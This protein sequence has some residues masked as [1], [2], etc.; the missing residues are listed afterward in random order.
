MHDEQERGTWS[1]SEAER[2]L[3]AVLKYS[4]QYIYDKGKWLLNQIYFSFIFINS[5]FSLF[6]AYIMNIVI[7]ITN[8]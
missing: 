6:P 3:R 8:W 4:K 1:D 7:H 2:L 5:E